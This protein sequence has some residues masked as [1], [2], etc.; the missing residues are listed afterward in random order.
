MFVQRFAKAIAVFVSLAITTIF[1][2]FDSLRWLSLFTAALIVVWMVAA[3]YAGRRFT[4]LSSRASP[5]D[6]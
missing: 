4:A 1:V 3:F 6:S 2:E 5:K